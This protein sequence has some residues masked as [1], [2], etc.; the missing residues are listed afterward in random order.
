MPKHIN[1]LQPMLISTT[2]TE[3]GFQGQKWGASPENR[4]IPPSNDG[5]GASG[6]YHPLRGREIFLELKWH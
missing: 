5:R 6:K 4:R 3:G 1:D 2:P